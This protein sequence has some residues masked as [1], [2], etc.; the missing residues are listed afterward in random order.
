MICRSLGLKIGIFSSLC[1]RRDCVGSCV[2]WTLVDE[3]NRQ[4]PIDSRTKINK[5]KMSDE[6]CLTFVTSWQSRFPTQTRNKRY[7]VL[8]WEFRSF[9]EKAKELI[10]FQKIIRMASLATCFTRHNR[11][12]KWFRRLADRWPIVQVTSWPAM[13]ISQTIHI[14]RF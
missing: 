6:S 11:S 12:V 5:A 13:S 14:D 4:N 10:L 9:L 8:V 2:W 3:T 7:F 1:G